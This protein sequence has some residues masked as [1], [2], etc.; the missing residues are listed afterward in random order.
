[1]NHGISAGRARAIPRSTAAISKKDKAH[2][3]PQTMREEALNVLT[4]GVGAV[5]AVIGTI[6]LVVR[7][8][9][10]GGTLSVVSTALYGAS[11][12]FLYTASSVYHCAGVPETKRRL[13]ML[14][15]CSIFLLI[16]GT[17]IPMSLV[18]IGGPLGWGL[19]AVNAT[20]AVV[21]IVSRVVSMSKGKSRLSVA[22]Y[23]IMGWLV[24]LAIKP[25]V[26]TLPAAGL[27]LLVAGG[28]AYTGGVWFYRNNGKYMHVIWHLF[29][30]AGS[31]LHYACVLLYCCG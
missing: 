11:L 27:A 1:M 29:V 8:A 30:L 5:L 25:V 4:H 28:V 26:E 17:Y 16:L 24:V 9:L 15:H 12:I 14:D 10:H 22:L 13:R 21:G 7:A 31:A 18:L 20:L 3:R 19:F 2:S 23:L 6:V